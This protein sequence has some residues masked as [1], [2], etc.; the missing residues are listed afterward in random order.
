[1][2]LIA[3]SF[4]VN[5]LSQFENTWLVKDAREKCKVLQLVKMDAIIVDRENIIQTGKMDAI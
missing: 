3:F 1:M 2:F 4:C 5:C